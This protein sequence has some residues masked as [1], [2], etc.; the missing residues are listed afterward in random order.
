MEKAGTAINA[1]YQ[2]LR[3]YEALDIEG[4][5]YCLTEDI[6]WIGTGWHELRFGKNE[7]L[8]LLEDDFLNDPTP[9]KANILEIRVSV[10]RPGVSSIFALIRFSR[11]SELSLSI[12]SRCTYVCVEPE[13]GYK[14]CSWHCSVGTALLAEDEYF[15]VTF[16]NNIMQKATEDAL[17]HLMNRA[18]F[19]EFTAS[20]LKTQSDPLAYILIDLDDFK[21][22]NDYYGHSCGDSVL[23]FAARQLC[24]SFGDKAS[25]ARWG[26]DEF[27][28]LV[29]CVESEASVVQLVSHFLDHFSQPM[30]L[31]AQPYT[32][33]AS[34]GIF[35]VQKNQKIAMNTATKRQMTPCAKPRKAAKTHGRS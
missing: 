22:V 5:L 3:A 31:N 9:Y 17:T 32:P 14:I 7:I 28:V 21:Y 20:Y 27:V 23:K 11:G 6:V 12:D 19:E 15:P 8:P 33:S 16:A 35:L 4:V 13:E 24:Q 34:I 26:G 1:V 25:I 30:D 29:P 2:L 10:V 18:S